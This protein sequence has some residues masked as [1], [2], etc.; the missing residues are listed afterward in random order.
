MIYI[1]QNKIRVSCYGCRNVQFIPIEHKNTFKVQ[2]T[3]GFE[4]EH[5]FKGNLVC[6]DCG[7]KL[8][9][10]ILCFEYPD[11]ILN[12]VDIENEGCVELDDNT[13]IFTF[14]KPNHE[15]S[16][17][18]WKEIKPIN[19]CRTFQFGDEPQIIHIIKLTGDDKYIIVYDDA[20]EE[21]TGNVK[22]LT[23]EEIYNNFKIKI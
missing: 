5:E 17:I 13:K 8:A 9:L 11:G 16:E 10:E 4:Y 14:D 2:R 22:I 23:S 20:F 12:Y 3:M 21:S 6:P 1:N 19:N 15:N 18:I 7:E